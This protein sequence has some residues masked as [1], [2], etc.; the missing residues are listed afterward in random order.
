M[1]PTYLGLSI[2][3]GINAFFG[4]HSLWGPRSVTYYHK[5]KHDYDQVK[6]QEWALLKREKHQLQRK[7]ALLGRNIDAD[8]LSQQAWNVAGYVHPEDLVIYR[9][10]A[11][12]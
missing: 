1:L 7:I 2:L 4:Y 11:E 12:S 9:N 10:G 5:L 6:V 8:L 3:M